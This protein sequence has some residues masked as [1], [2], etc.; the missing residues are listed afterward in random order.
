MSELIITEKPSSAKKIAESLADGKPK[1]EVVNGVTIFSLTHGK[2]DIRVVSAVGHLY[3]LAE[4]VKSFAYPV[5]DIEW[6]PIHL[7]NKKAVFSK[8][9]LDVIKKESKKAKSFVVA[10]DYDIEGEV[11][12][13]NIVRFVCNQK[14]ASRMKFSTLVKEDVIKSYDNKLPSLDWGQALAGETRHFLDWLYGINISRALSTSV[15]KAGAFKILSSGRVQ[16]PALKIVADKE[17][18]IQA[19]KPVPFW[20]VVLELNKKIKFDAI[21]EKDKFWDEKEAKTVFNKVKDK[22][23]CVVESL[24][25]KK[26]AQQAPFPFDLGSLQSEAYKLFGISPKAT[27]QCAQSLYLQGLTSYPRTSSQKL[28]KEL[29]LSKVISDLAKNPEY[30]NS[31]E[32]LLSKKLLKPNEGK[33]DDPAHPAI[34]P[35]GSKGKI[36]DDR[37]KKVYD[38][39]VKRF[40]ACFGEPAI[41]ETVTAKFVVAEELF[42]SKGTSTL[43]KGWHELYEPYVKLSEDELPVL[44]KDDVV[45]IKKSDLLSKETQPPKRFTPASLISELEKKGLGTK[46]T[47]ADIVEALYD[48]GY[49]IEKSIQVTQ[50][51]MHT[52]HVMEKYFKELTDEEF[53]RD[54]EDQMELIRSKKKKP[55]DVLDDAKKN[56]M[57]ILDKIKKHEKSI[58]EELLS[59]NKETQDTKNLLGPCPLCEEGSIMIKRG[60][61]GLFAA[62]SKY[63]DCKETF[64][65]P[66]QGL[67]K[68]TGK[69]S[70]LGYPIISL[71]VKG[72]RPVEL[73]LN[74]EENNH[75][76]EKTEEEYRS[77]KEGSVDKNCEKCGAPMRVMNSIYGEFLGCTNYPKCRHTESP[78]GHNKNGSNGVVKTENKESKEIIKD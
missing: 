74:P 23:D 39:I 15:K 7:V 65:L 28:P 33:K 48:R 75:L 30:K 27:L 58:G 57:V 21:H 42:V 12:G 37:E 62:C 56:L 72:K 51:G 66:K 9:Y 49:V 25:K 24:S 71:F 38:L 70:P 77:I 64:N 61:F 10:C 3:T 52:V 73:S 46:A 40:F 1:K 2:T 50:L 22:K 17:K 67:V 47:R 55:E 32:F 60:K 11:I 19:F 41:R 76:D 69:I 4:K 20:Q 59:A 78:N 31:A 54:V 68:P 8:K 29:N 44:Q 13:L 35:T 63:P 26:F 16:A 34:F 5:F 14:D 43:V 45:V 53:T 6:R 36:S 18:E